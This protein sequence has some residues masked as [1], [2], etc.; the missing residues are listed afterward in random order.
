MQTLN[1]ISPSAVIKSA[2]RITLLKNYN[3]GLI[4]LMI[5]LMIILIII[6]IILI[7]I[8]SY[9]YYYYSRALSASCLAAICRE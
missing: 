4:I 1:S 5:I 7:I 8:L 2:A 3:S 9:Y 6:I